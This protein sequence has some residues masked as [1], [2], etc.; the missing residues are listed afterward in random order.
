[1]IQDSINILKCKHLTRS[2]GSVVNYNS[3]EHILYTVIV[4]RS[5]RPITLKR[6]I[7]LTEEKS[8]QILKTDYKT[9]FC[10]LQNGNFLSLPQAKA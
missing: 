5:P 8:M 9:E 4:V 3:K 10:I 2:P 6:K 1:M 7:T